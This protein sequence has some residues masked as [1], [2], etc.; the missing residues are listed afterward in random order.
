MTNALYS[1]ANNMQI[2]TEKIYE[3]RHSNNFYII[4]CLIDKNYLVNN[5]LHE[6][7]VTHDNNRRISIGSDVKSHLYLRNHENKYSKLFN[8][9]LDLLIIHK[10]IM[11]IN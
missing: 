4:H 10:I 11:I 1:N 2:R 3:W 8:N 5:C 6:K 7:Y 9:I